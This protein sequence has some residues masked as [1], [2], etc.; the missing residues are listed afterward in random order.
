MREKTT[1]MSQNKGKWQK[2]KLA[3][4]ALATVLLL[5]PT[6]AFAT[7]G[8]CFWKNQDKKEIV[9]KTPAVA[10]SDSTITWEETVSWPNLEPNPEWWEISQ[11]EIQEYIKNHKK[12]LVENIDKQVAEELYKE[13]IVDET[14]QEVIKDLVNDADIRQAVLDGNEEYIKQEIARKIVSP[15]E[16]LLASLI[17]YIGA[18]LIGYWAGRK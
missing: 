17:A 2:R 11:E 12:E 13:I 4:A 7:S 15:W 1:L 16:R 6:V 3:G 9:A 10:K 8:K 5:T 14:I 18:L